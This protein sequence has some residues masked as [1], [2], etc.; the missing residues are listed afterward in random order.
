[1]DL[2]SNS[3]I[4]ENQKENLSSFFFEFNPIKEFFLLH[5]NPNFK[6]V[7]E[8]QKALY[9][10]EFEKYFFINETDEIAKGLI[11]LIY[12]L[13][14]ALFHGEVLPDKKHIKIYENAYHIIRIVL[15]YIV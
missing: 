1:M 3:S 11:E 2:D 13:R 6:E 15:D 4:T 14:N 10:L 7:S 8:K 12:R 5:S 9:Y